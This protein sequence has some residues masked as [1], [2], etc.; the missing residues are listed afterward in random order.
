[1]A[2]IKNTKSD[3]MQRILKNSNNDMA[4]TLSESDFFNNPENIPLSVP[5]MN[6]GFSGNIDDGFGTGWNIIAG[7]SRH[8]KTSFGLMA[9]KAFMDKYDDGI[10]IFYDSEFGSPKGYLESYGLDLSRIVHHPIEHIEQLKFDICTQLEDIKADDHVMIFI[11]SLGGLASKKEYTDA[12]AEKSVADMTR[13]KEIKSLM[14]LTTPKLNIRKIPGVVIAHTYQ[15]MEMFSKTILGGGQGMMLAPNTVWFVGRSK[16]KNKDTKEVLGYTFTIK[17]EKSR[18]VKED[19]R[20]PI[21]VSF[22]RGIKKWS[23]LIDL[24]V[25][26]DVVEKTTAARGK[27]AYKFGDLL[28]LHDDISE[29]DEFWTKVFKETDLAE[30]IRQKYTMGCKDESGVKFEFEEGDLVSADSISEDK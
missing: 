11:D 23:G 19:S 1:M 18:V 8:F 29:A 27:T 15:T 22:D 28:V 2:K 9:V 26:F 20:F 30:K 12:L 4:S 10:V 13:A 3:L 7:P 14:R 25:G 16:D 5:M 24:A 6:V 21:E 17:V